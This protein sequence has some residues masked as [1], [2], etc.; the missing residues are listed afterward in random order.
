MYVWSILFNWDWFR[1]YSIIV[2]VSRFFSFSYSEWFGHRSC[3]CVWVTVCP[4]QS[5]VLAAAVISCPAAADQPAAEL[6]RQIS[7]CLPGFLCF[8]WGAS[9]GF[10]LWPLTFN[11]SFPFSSAAPFSLRPRTRFYF[12][13][14]FYLRINMQLCCI[15][16]ILML[17]FQKPKVIFSV[18]HFSPL[19]FCYCFPGW[20]HL[21][22]IM[23][24]RILA[25][26]ALCS[27]MG[28]SFRR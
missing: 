8:V 14:Y 7:P 1:L 13:F 6:E 18:G 19:S 2:S 24:P 16:F 28:F 9:W 5:G 3:C 12:Y 27:K 26:S 22:S 11:L 15:L 17:P 25:V 20:C 10:L 23:K 4:C 21:Y